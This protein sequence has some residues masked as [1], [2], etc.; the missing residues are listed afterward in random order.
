MLY[1]IKY[2]HCP[3]IYPLI[4]TFL[5]VS[6]DSKPVVKNIS[7]N[8]IK[9][10]IPTCIH[11]VHPEFYLLHKNYVYK[12]SSALNISVGKTADFKS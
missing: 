9:L 3:A 4:L 11:K 6:K 5:E 1:Q 7:N 8:S 10:G 12:K 2:C